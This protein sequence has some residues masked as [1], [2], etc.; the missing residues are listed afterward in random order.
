MFPPICFV[1]VTK[2]AVAYEETEK[3]MKE[4]LSDEEYNMVNNKA[5]EENK[6]NKD[7]KTVENSKTSKEN[8]KAK[9]VSKESN[10]ATSKKSNTT[11]AKNSNNIAKNDTEKSNSKDILGL[12]KEKMVDNT[13]DNNVIIKFKIGELLKSL[14]E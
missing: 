9:V 11:A 7:N 3:E 2:G 6:K 1:D 14:V 10:K 12:E 4:V 13:E 8:S 5:S